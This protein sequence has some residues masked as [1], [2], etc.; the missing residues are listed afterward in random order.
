[1][2]A[3]SIVITEKTSRRKISVLPLVLATE[4]FFRPRAICRPAQ[5]PEDVVARAGHRFSCGPTAFTA[6][7]RLRAAQTAKLKAIPKPALGQ[8]SP[9][10]TDCD[11]EVTIGQEI[12]EHYQYRGQSCDCCSPPGLQTIRD[13]LPGEPNSEYASLCAAAIARRQAD[14]STTCR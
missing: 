8:T 9:L 10:A 7:A 3:G 12:L 2:M 14:R 5:E 6:L 1:M 11:R 13:A 4:T